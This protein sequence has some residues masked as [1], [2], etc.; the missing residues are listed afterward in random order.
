MKLRSWSVTI[1]ALTIIGACAAGT[2]SSETRAQ[3]DNSVIT[4]TELRQAVESNLLDYIRAHR[5]MWLQR[6]RPTA[7]RPDRESEV[8]VYLDNT[9]MGGPETLR[10]FAPSSAMLVRYF[11]PTSAHSRFGPGH[12]NGVIQ[13]ITQGPR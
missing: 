9:R 1:G 12:L 6:A 7:I 3:A 4:A 8:V 2:G 5:P 13:M 11:T 10:E